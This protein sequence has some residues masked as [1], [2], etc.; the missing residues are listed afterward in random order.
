[1]QCSYSS[2]ATII[3]I[4]GGEFQ[5][6]TETEHIELELCV[7]CIPHLNDCFLKL[8]RKLNSGVRPNL[9]STFLIHIHKISNGHN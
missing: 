1:M 5:N 9:L 3:S 6:P 4:A 7:N 8:Y 2:I